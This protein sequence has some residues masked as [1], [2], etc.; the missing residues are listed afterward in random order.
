MQIWSCALI[1]TIPGE[2]ERKFWL[3]LCLFLVREM[4]YVEGAS[5]EKAAP[6]A[7]GVRS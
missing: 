1:A 5:M 6:G 4:L 3:C 7:E 2:E